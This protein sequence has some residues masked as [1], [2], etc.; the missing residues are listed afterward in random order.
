MSLIKKS[1]FPTPTFLSLSMTFQVLTIGFQ[2]LGFRDQVSSMALS[3]SQMRAVEFSL[4]EY[5]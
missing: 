4:L 2:K 5:V 1:S 3:A